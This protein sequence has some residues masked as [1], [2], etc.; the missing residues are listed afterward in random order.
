M[1]PGG[2]SV[3]APVPLTATHDRESFACGVV[4]LDEWLKKRALRNEAA[5]ASRTYVVCAG[6]T[7][8][9]YYALAAGGMARSGAPP[10]MRRNMPDPI[11]AMVLGR[12]AVDRRYQ[13]RGLGQDLLRDAVERV[14]RAADIVGI[15]AILV[16]AISEEAKRFYLAQEF[17]EF[18]EEPMTLCLPLETVRQA[19]RGQEAG[20]S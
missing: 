3:S 1:I 8:V 18:P 12:L 14:L 15:K 10:S 17:L 11:P 19:L 5:G 2:S 16:H 20:G 7:V 6:T 9:G 4:I 13:R